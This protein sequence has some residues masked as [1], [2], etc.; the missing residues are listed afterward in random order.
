MSNFNV[1]KKAGQLDRAG[2]L[3]GDEIIEVSQSGAARSVNLRMVHNLNITPVQAVAS[4]GILTCTGVV[5]HG[6]TLI[7]GVETI[8]FDTGG[9]V[10]GGTGVVNCD[11]S[12]HADKAQSV[13]TMADVG[14]EGDIIIIG[15]DTFEI[16]ALEA[17]ITPGNIWVD[18]GDA[19][20]QTV[21]TN[22]V[23]A[24]VANG[25]EDITYTDNAND[26]MGIEVNAGGTDG[27]LIT[28]DDDNLTNGSI[29][30]NSGDFLGGTQAGTDATAQNALEEV[31]GLTLHDAAAVNNDDDTATFTAKKKGVIGDTVIFNADGMALATVDSGTDV[32]G[33]S[34]AGVNGTVGHKGQIAYD[35]S[36]LYICAAENTIHDANWEKTTISLATY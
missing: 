7:V 12:A 33:E 8:E 17:S 21:V 34:V 22:L 5:L 14:V 31:E 6:E 19:A 4:E 11:I 15:D 27:N 30:D 20:K 26:T 16:T 18:L 28:W 32:L 10:V 23:A 13:L 1:A 36:N 9:V 35:A 24:M 3:V 2:T 29:N 25:T